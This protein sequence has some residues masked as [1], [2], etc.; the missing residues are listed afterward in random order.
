MKKN[1]LVG[2]CEE[3]IED[4]FLMTPSIFFDDRGYF[5]E[6]WN[7]KEFNQLIGKSI[8]FV[9]DNHSFSKQGVIRGLH[10]QLPPFQQSKLVTCISGEIFDVAVDIRKK[11]PTF[12]SWAGAYLNEDNQNQLWVPEGF[13]HGFIVI[14]SSALVSYKVDQYWKK[15]YE[16]SIR[17]DDQNLKISW[18]VEVKRGLISEKDSNSFH[19][20]DLDEDQLF[21]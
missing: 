18:P 20:L 10:Y 5:S 9:Q 1:S 7:K 11:S 6:S 17:W 16:R 4:L 12:G 21:P 3:I 2:N 14:S 15:N 8:D 19:F 13:A